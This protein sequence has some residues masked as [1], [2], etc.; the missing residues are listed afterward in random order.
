ML[1]LEES[2]QLHK[3]IQLIIYLIFAASGKSKSASPAFTNGMRDGERQSANVY[4][5]HPIGLFIA[6]LR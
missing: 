3:Q 1:L 5:V 4:R 6:L 2:M